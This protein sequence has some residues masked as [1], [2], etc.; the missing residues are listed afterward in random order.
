M[1][2]AACSS[3]P[4]DGVAVAD[5]EVDRAVDLLVEERVSHV[6]RDPG[7]AADPELAEP[8]RALVR[9]EHREQMVLAVV[10][11]RSDDDA[12]PELEPRAGD[13][14]ALVDDGELGERDVALGRVLHRPEEELARRACLRGRVDRRRPDPRCESVRSVS[15]PT[16]RTSLARRSAR[17]SGASARLGVPVAQAGA[18]DDSP[19]TRPASSRPLPPT[20][21]SGTASPPSGRRASRPRSAAGSCERWISRRRSGS[22]SAPACRSSAR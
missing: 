18:V 16:I 13:V 14:A 1:D 21:R 6:P 3:P 8:P 20:L 4:D 22:R 11:A 7:V 17:R 5:G 19:R 15:A 2:R 10:G 9:I 12:A